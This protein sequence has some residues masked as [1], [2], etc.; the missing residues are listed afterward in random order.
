MNRILV[1]ILVA[2][3]VSAFALDAAAQDRDLTLELGIRGFM[4]EL[5]GRLRNG[6]GPSHV[7]I[8]DDLDAGD[9]ATGM[10]ISLTGRLAGGFV[11]NVQGW[12][13]QSEGESTITE[14]QAWGNLVL[15][16]GGTVDTDVDVRYVSAK[17]LFG[18]TPE[19]NPLQVGLGFAG[20]VIDWK[21]EL[22]LDTG[23]RETLK[24]R[25]IYPA[26]EIEVAYQ[27]GEA[28][29]LHAEGSL[30]MPAYEKNGV[31]V[32]SPYELRAGAR[33]M[34]GAVTIEGGYQVYDAL[35]IS[36]ENQPEEESANVNLN[37]IYFEV[38][39]RF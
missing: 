33:I 29:I 31:E 11:M 10:G 27:I 5:D 16:P 26:A 4:G 39:A 15:A 37:G 21:T 13:Y 30:G 6:P 19:R 18:L 36:D 1:P 17:F 2:A 9:D 24:M 25:V 34:F 32:Q 28:V 8:S 7:T 12:Q 23:E 14:G 35:L 3:A 22:M 38:A 20:K